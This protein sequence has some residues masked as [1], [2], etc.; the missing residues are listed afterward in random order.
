MHFFRVPAPHRQPRLVGKAIFG[1]RIMGAIARIAAAR[2][3]QGSARSTIRILHTTCVQWECNGSRRY[4][5]ADCASSEFRAMGARSAPRTGEVH[6]EGSRS[7]LLFLRP[8][9][10]DRE[11][12]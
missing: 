8:Y 9:R 1:T 11:C 3:N 4:D 5:L 2:L 12:G 7:P 10:D 6:V